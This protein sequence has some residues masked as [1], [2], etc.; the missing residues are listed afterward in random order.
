MKAYS[1]SPLSAKDRVIASVIALISLLASHSPAVGTAYA[2]TSTSEKALV[3]QIKPQTNISSSSLSTVTGNQKLAYEQHVGQIDARVKAV[4]AYLESKNAPLAQYTEI[5]LAQEDW[6]K[7]LAISNAES[8][9]GR[10]C[11]KNNC[12]GIMYGRGGLRPFDS[13]PDWIVELQGLIDRR[14]KNKTLDQMN[15]VYVVPR[16]ANWYQ[17]S[18]SVYQALTEIEK[19]TPITPVVNTEA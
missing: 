4:R 6:K 2:Q 5:I 17:A 11:W 13:I 10:H 7:I 12:S 16:S 1:S 14:Y 15:G 19:Q 8:N 18:N 3:F 9:M